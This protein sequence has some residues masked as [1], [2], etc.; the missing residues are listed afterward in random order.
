MKVNGLTFNPRGRAGQ[1]TILI[2]TAARTITLRDIQMRMGSIVLYQGDLEFPVPAEETFT[3]ASID[4]DT[5][6]KSDEPPADSEAALDL[7]GDDDAQAA[8][9]PIRGTAKLELSKGKALL[10]ASVELP[11]AFTDAEGRGLTGELRISSDNANGFKLAGAKIAAPLA[12]VGKVELQNL[13]VAFIGDGDGAVSETCNLPSGGLRWEGK[14]E[15]LV[16]PAPGKPKITN[17]GFGLADGA[18]AH[19][20]GTLVPGGDG[21]ELGAGIRVTKLSV[22]LCAG[23]PVRIEG[24]AGLTALPGADGKPRLII[25]D[26]GLIYTGPDQG[27]S[28]TIRAETPQAKIAGDIPI[29]FDD[30]FLQVGGNGAV[31][32]GGKVR[33]SVPLKGSAG[34]VSLDAKVDVEAS[35][36]GFVEGSRYN[37]ELA[38][39]GCFAGS[40]EVSPAPK[41]SFDE[42]CPQVEGLISSTGF[43]VCGALTVKGKSIGRV[44]AGKAWD[45]DLRFMSG[46]CDLGPWRV[47]RELPEPPA[48]EV[49]P[50]TPEGAAARRSAAGER[51]FSIPAGARN[52]LV[53]LRGDRIPPRVELVGPNGERIPTPV[54]PGR[55]AR[56]DHS[57]AF[58]NRAL[59]TTY[60]GLSAPRAGTWTARP[61]GTAAD[62]AVQRI[63][64]APLLAPARISGRLTGHGRGVHTLTVRAT[65]RPGQRITLLER[66]TGVARASSARC[67]SAEARSASGPRR[68]RPAAAPS[69]HSSTRTASRASGAPSR[70]SSPSVRRRRPGRPRS[71]SRGRRRR[72]PSVGRPPRAPRATGSASRRPT[73]APACSSVMAAAAR[74][75]FRCPTARSTSRSASSDCAPTTPPA[76]PPRPARLAAAPPRPT[77]VT[78]E[79]SRPPPNHPIPH[80]PQVPALHRPGA[81]VR[82]HPQRRRASAR[83]RCAERDARRAIRHA[84]DVDRQ[85]DVR[86]R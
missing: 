75:G 39:K 48:E 30:L 18:F 60:V 74:C 80:D 33:F 68:A 54:D 11:K 15:T 77:G 43:A 45:G 37:V 20:E 72:S 62:G 40:F 23:P 17:V 19:A 29:T 86:R 28:W 38:A 65:A 83:R 73:V 51:R 63:A 55:T 67:A 58:T 16:F 3:L 8:G 26:A 36:K 61:A 59:A 71:A 70:P 78:D 49:P 57:V 9:L 2:D 64:V 56:T 79:S 13:S 14:A 6:S 53:A 82:A 5:K 69:R 31:D 44:G 10:T 27:K 84:H 35:A 7:K 42:I 85:L 52:V 4:T 50:T 81:R 46:S 22:S 1:Y 21:A 47:A 25:P 41:V 34:P 66:G 24:R 76:V 12:Y 32:F